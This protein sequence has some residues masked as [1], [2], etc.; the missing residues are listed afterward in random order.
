MS[1]QL[2]TRFQIC[3]V[4]EFTRYLLRKSS[5]LVLSSFPALLC[6][7]RQGNLALVD[8]TSCS[9]QNPSMSKVLNLSTKSLPSIRQCEG[10]KEGWA[11]LG[12]MCVYIHI[13]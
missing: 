2:P 10:V 8:V 11:S 7:W 13:A 9:S 3:V 12:R 5:A 4:S 6:P 1:N